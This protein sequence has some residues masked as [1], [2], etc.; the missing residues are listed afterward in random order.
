MSPICKASSAASAAGGPGDAGALK[1]PS[2]GE[3]LAPNGGGGGSSPA[4]RSVPMSTDSSADRLGRGESSAGSANVDPSANARL[5]RSLEDYEPMAVRTL[6]S[7]ELPSQA[8]IDEHN[9][10]HL[11]YRSWCRFCVMGRGKAD[12]HMKRLMLVQCLRA[13]RR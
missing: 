3:D 10:S 12:F 13:P 2:A 8:E 11:P 6:V 4:A 1:E 7:P 9:V 5:K